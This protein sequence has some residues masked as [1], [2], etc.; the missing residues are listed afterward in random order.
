MYLKPVSARSSKGLGPPIA[1]RINS[2]VL[3]IDF[4]RSVLVRIMAQATSVSRQQ[5][6]RWYGLT[7]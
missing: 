2:G 6:S 7:M 1:P 5:S 4:A 3:R